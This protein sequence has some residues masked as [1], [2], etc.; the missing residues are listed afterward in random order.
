MLHFAKRFCFTA[1]LSVAVMAAMTSSAAA[2][3]NE[4][5]LNAGCS[6]YTFY[7][8]N[9]VVGAYTTDYWG[10]L[11]PGTA[12]GVATNSFTVIRYNGCSWWPDN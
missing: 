4:T 6:T 8:G 10:L 12:W 2:H 1:F 3:K 7:S 11:V 5:S 9:E